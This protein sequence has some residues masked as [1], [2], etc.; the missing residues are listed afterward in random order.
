MCYSTIDEQ[1]RSRLAACLSGAFCPFRPGGRRLAPKERRSTA[2]AGICRRSPPA[3]QKQDHSK[4]HRW[5]VPCSFSEA[6]MRPD[7]KRVAEHT[8]VWSR[9]LTQ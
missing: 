3:S 4:I 1:G 8:F 5:Q 9:G 2:S 6:E 7:K